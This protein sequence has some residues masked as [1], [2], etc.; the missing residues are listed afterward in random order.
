M[1]LVVA[2]F[3]CNSIGAPLAQNAP[4]EETFSFRKQCQ[5]QARGLCGSYFASSPSKQRETAY[6]IWLRIHQRIDKID[7][8]APQIYNRYFFSVLVTAML[9]LSIIIFLVAN[10][11]WRFSPTRLIGGALAILLAV[12]NA[13]GWSEEYKSTYQAWIDLVSL[14]D[15]VEANIVQT[16]SA[17]DHPL[18]IE[19]WLK[20]YNLIRARQADSYTKSLSLPNFNLIVRGV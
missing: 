14:R 11:K 17:P 1:V 6:Y 20:R 19:D 9:A 7:K 16:H 2:V 5:P 18:P 4:V 12:A 10:V 3:T 15:E 13:L 8:E